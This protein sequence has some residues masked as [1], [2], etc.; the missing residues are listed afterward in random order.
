MYI[1]ED[2]RKKREEIAANIAKS[3]GCDFEKAHNHGDVHPNGKWYWESSANGGKG[4]WRTIKRV[5]KTA[6]ATTVTETEVVKK[7]DDN[8]IVITAKQ[9]FADIQ[10]LNPSTSTV[11]SIGTFVSSQNQQIADNE[12]K[13][14]MGYLPKDSLAYKIVSS[15][16]KFSDKQLW[17]IAYELIKN[18]DYQKDL[19]ESIEESERQAAYQKARK[20]AKRKA[21]SEQKKQAKATADDAMRKYDDIDSDDKVEHPTFGV[22][23]VM[24]QTDD[25]ITVFFNT[26]GEKVLLKKF[27]PLKK[28]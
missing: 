9:A 24:S 21:K 14:I 15:A 28:L 11:S 17:V 20:S 27:A 2:V 12:A 25:K 10:S 26:V 22:G 18:K 23:K 13:R 16:S 6:S 19:A 8:K 7:K 3:F 5:G 4:D 1:E